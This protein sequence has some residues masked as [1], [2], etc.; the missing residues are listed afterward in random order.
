MPGT[1][2]IIPFFQYDA[3]VLSAAIRSALTQRDAG[4]ITV[5]VCD[6]GSPVSA[7]AELAALTCGERERVI[8]VRQA[9]AGVGPARNAALDAMPPDTEWI[10][11]LDSDDRWLPDHIARSVAALQE[12]YD[13]CFAN[14]QRD[15]EALTHFQYASFDPRQHEPIGGLPG[16]YRFT[17]DFLTQNL[18]MA[19][20]SV[21]SVVMRASTLGKLRFAPTMFEDLTFWFEVARRGAR[22]AFDGTLQVQYG[23][24]NITLTESW[25]SPRELL[26]RLAFQGVF[27]RVWRSFVLTPP[28]RIILRRRMAHNRRLF[29]TTLLA[30]LH[31]GRA[32]GWDVVTG[33]VALDPLVVRTLAGTAIREVVQRLPLRRGKAVPALPDLR[34]TTSPG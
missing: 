28:Q 26:N 32:P 17:G 27:M 31:G 33:F 20:V 21:S 10:A 24:G 25:K 4:R 19:P 6:D 9:N 23:A 8:L 2:V 18:T 3:G 15:T 1:A 14:V 16:L 30:L 5:V 11:F 13:F 34:D 12:G 29:C 22:V 7:A